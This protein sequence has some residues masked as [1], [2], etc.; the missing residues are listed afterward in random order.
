MTREAE[1]NF[2]SEHENLA[3]IACKLYDF[4]VKASIEIPPFQT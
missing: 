3:R 2:V 4:A 1:M